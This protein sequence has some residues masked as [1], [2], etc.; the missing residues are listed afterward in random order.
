MTKIEIKNK[1]FI[2]KKLNASVL[3]IGYIGVV[4]RNF[5]EQNTFHI[6]HA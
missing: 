2:H 5:I 1:S 3:M 4:G 6:E